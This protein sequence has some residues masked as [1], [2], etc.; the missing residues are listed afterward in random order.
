[1][2]N[3]HYL[4]DTDE[5]HTP[6]HR[7]FA[8]NAART[9]DAGPYVADQVTN[10]ITAL[11][12]DT[13]TVYYLTNHSPVTWTSLTG[14]SG[15]TNTG[16]NVGSG[17]GTVFRD[18]TGT[19]LNFKTLTAGTNI[20][21]NNNADD[22]EIVAAGGG[23][24]E[25][26]TASNVNVGGVGVFKQKA[27]VDLEFRGVNAASSKVSV[28][29]DAGNNE[30]D[31]D[32]VEASVDHDALLNF[33]AAE[34]IDWT[35]SG[36]GTI[37][38]DNYIEGGPGT[39]TDAIHDNV[40]GEIAAVAL[41]GTPVGADLLLIE[42]SAAA[43]AKKRIAISSL[44]SGGGEA[45]TASNVGSGADVFKQ[46]TGVDLE[47][48]GITGVAPINAVVNADNID[49][50][51]G[52]TLAQLNASISDATLDDAGDTRPPSAHNHAAADVTSGAFA[53][54]RIS[55]SSVTQHEGALDH[56]GI[57]GLADDD[58]TQYTRADGTRAFTGP[59]SMGSNDLTNIK[60]PTL[61]VVAAGNISGAVT[62]NFTNGA[63]VTAT[64]TGNV[65]FSI[66]D[67][68]GPARM[69]VI[70]KQDGTGNRTITLPTGVYTVNGSQPN[71]S[72]QASEAN[73]LTFVFDG[74]DHF[75][76][77]SGDLDTL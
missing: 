46:K 4:F 23:G 31:V 72:N 54:A 45:N 76:L 15:E 41:K 20:T 42:D 14:G 17:T 75:A 34:H 66:T 8:D 44:P 56:G 9:A 74:T 47:F 3:L 73:V 52:G 35:Q 55:Q 33:V 43:N 28:A 12:L 36:A 10:P 2:T 62:L 64:L 63:L 77:V 69:S 7:V 11:Q 6:Y 26:N 25:A 40:A 49:V 32:V 22:I 58:H 21:L 61:V 38:V 24:G 60:V 67:P 1:M 16:A 13:A 27:G 71:L 51:L 65:T 18:K 70:L 30:I 37:H 57:G 29:L 53:D 68:P 5:I 50:S 59:Q 19:T 39:D 48:R